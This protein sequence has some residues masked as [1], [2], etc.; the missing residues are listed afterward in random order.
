MKSYKRCANTVL[1]SIIAIA[2]SLVMTCSLFDMSV[3]AWEGDIYKQGQYLQPT[4]DINVANDSIVLYESEIAGYY[5]IDIDQYMSGNGPF[6]FLQNGDTCTLHFSEE[7]SEVTFVYSA[8]DGMWHNDTYG[9]I[10]LQY[11]NDYSSWQPGGENYFTM[12]YNAEY[13]DGSQYQT[14]VA[15]GR[16]P[17]TL[18]SYEEYELIK[19]KPQAKQQIRYYLLG[20]GDSSSPLVNYRPEDQTLI[21]NMVTEAEAAIDAAKTSAEVKEIENSTIDDFYKI[22]TITDLEMIDTYYNQALENIAVYDTDSWLDLYSSDTKPVVKGIV[23]EG[24]SKVN[25]LYSNAYGPIDQRTYDTYDGYVTAFDDIYAE[26]QTSVLAVETRKQ[27]G[28]LEVRLSQTEF[29]YNGAVQMPAVTVFADGKQLPAS[30]YRLVWPAGMVNVG[31]YLVEAVLTDT[32]TGSN[33]EA[34]RIIPAFNNMTASG[35][36]VTLKAKKL[37]KKAQTVNMSKAYTIYNP[38]GTLTYTFAGVNKD[39]YR[40]Y[41]KVNPYNGNIT[42]KK[43]LKKGTYKILVHI[44][45]DGGDNYDYADQ[46]VTV[47]IKVKK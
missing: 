30:E 37:K 8:D 24:R 33:A 9:S 41:F 35:N 39:K 45:D 21:R 42:V 3:F 31:D 20:E 12:T 7:P 18:K 44:E 38:K 2:L 22:F 5:Y 36:K 4:I 32:Y 23:A 15:S 19:A 27:P 29:V 28:S 10:Y 25:E 40:K 13:F 34:F 16:I 14:I 46:Y 17:V 6:D 47:T 43:K 1:S 26:T 11:Q